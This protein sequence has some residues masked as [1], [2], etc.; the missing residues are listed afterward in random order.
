M[1]RKWPDWLRI[2]LAA[3]LVP[4]VP[5]LV[6]R[7]VIQTPLSAGYLNIDYAIAT[8]VFVFGLRNLG[9]G[10]MVLGLLCD[11]LRTFDVIFHFSQ[12]DFFYAAAYVTDLPFALVAKNVVLL[13]TIG[14]LI[15]ALWRQLLAGTVLRSNR[16]V[17]VALLLFTVSLKGIDTLNG[18]NSYFRLRES[19]AGPN[20]V[21]ESIIGTAR[22][23][24]LMFRPAVPNVPIES[25]SSPL[26]S[27]AT[28]VATEADEPNVVL[29]L[30]ESM[31]DAPTP[32]R[33]Y[34][35]V[36]E[37]PT[38]ADRYLVEVGRVPFVGSTVAGEYRELCGLTS[39]TRIRNEELS[40]REGCLP[41]IY[42]KKGYE[43]EGIHGYQGRMFARKVWYP[44]LGF[45][46]LTFLEQLR[47]NPQMHVCG[48]AFPGICDTDIARYIGTRLKQ[49]GKKKFIHWMTLNT[50][51]PVERSVERER[52]CENTREIDVCE[53]E[54]LL[55][56]TLTGI[57]DLADD[58]NVPPTEFIIV[59]DHAPPFATLSR[60]NAFDQ[61]YV[62]FVRLIPRT[63]SRKPVLL[64]ASQENGLRARHVAKMKLQ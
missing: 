34:L 25:A 59:G 64:K 33:N 32:D 1:F 47:S 22:S 13:A 19:F 52:Q 23:I 53:L 35:D 8:L 43:T 36:F 51:L 55:R 15:V 9:L 5:M 26:L 38:L 28:L 21:A 41:E 14:F 12:Q 27:R 10:L 50:H 42:N 30:V 61:K 4:N 20:L 45:Q 2:S 40:H 63:E 39:G 18:S 16:R 46:K 44:S 60:R 58:P 6:A 54:S 11:A 31:G 49:P 7:R 62:P 57:A 48:G 17:A 24:G 56:T 29:I 37:R 3:L